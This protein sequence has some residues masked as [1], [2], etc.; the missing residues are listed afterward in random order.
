MEI[1]ILK[2]RRAGWKHCVCALTVLPAPPTI[3]HYTSGR[4]M[5]ALCLRP[6][7]YQ[8]EQREGTSL[9]GWYPRLKSE[10]DPRV[11]VLDLLLG[12]IVTV[13]YLSRGSEGGDL[14]LHG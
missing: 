13:S 1:F 6:F 14:Y 10:M 5:W 9:R 12:V 11:S 2:N 7:K 8:R 3:S 4:S